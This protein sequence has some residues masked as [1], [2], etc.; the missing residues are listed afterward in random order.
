[1]DEYRQ[2]KPSY[3]V[4]KELNAPAAI[5]AH[6][7][8]PSDTAPSRFSATVTPNGT[9]SLPYYPLHD[10]KLVWQVSDEGGQLLASGGEQFSELKTA[11]VIS[12]QIESLANA[13]ALKLHLVLLRPGNTVAAETSVNWPG[14]EVAT[15]SSG[16]GGARAH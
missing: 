6:W 3:Y 5:S 1:V 7:E 14:G 8:G 4:W 13:K 11:Q 12:G 15:Q 10:Y 2:R 9:E 16:S